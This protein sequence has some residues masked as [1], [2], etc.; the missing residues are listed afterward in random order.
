MSFKVYAGNMYCGVLDIVID[1][2]I[3]HNLNNK[4]KAGEYINKY[5]QLRLVRNN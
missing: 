1:T 5:K 3:F 2:H 4:I